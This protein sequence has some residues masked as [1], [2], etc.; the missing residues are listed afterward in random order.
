VPQP[1][2]SQRVKLLLEATQQYREQVSAH[3]DDVFLEVASRADPRRGLGKADIGAL[4]AWKRLRADTAW[5]SRLM[6]IS[7]ADVRERTAACVRFAREES[8]PAP[9]AGQKAREALRVLPGFGQG[10]ALASALCTAAAPHRL[11]VYDQRARTGLHRVGL[12]L[13]DKGADFYRRY[14]LLLEQCQ[15]EVAQEG[16]TWTL[17]DVDLALFQLGRR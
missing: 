13:E 8:M 10:T 6:A 9:E 3:Y 11:A 7:D 16:V 17:R 4:V 12:E 5:M 14:L 15:Q 1:T 2:S